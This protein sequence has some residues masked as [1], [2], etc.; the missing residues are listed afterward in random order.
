M[1]NLLPTLFII[2][3][4][5]AL[6]LT[7]FWLWLSL[8]HTLAHADEAQ[9]AVPESSRSTAR[10][11]LLAEKQS[12]LMALKDL[13]A[14]RDTGK[15]SEADFADLNARY[16]A[17]ARTVLKSLD[18]QIAPHRETAKAMLKSAAE[19]LAL[20][21][22]AADTVSGKSTIPAP[23]TRDCPS[24]AASNDFDAAFCKKCG[25]KLE[26]EAMA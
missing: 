7:L 22:A 24:C 20:Q 9:V 4:A 1:Q 19:N 5:C 13:E 12:V 17:R 10:A 16:R 3:G 26:P 21:P 8:R 11:S 18:A 23:A 2:L 14:E 6:I 25:A 15:L